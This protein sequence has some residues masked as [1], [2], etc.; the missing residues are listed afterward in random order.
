VLLTLAF[1]A[2]IISIVLIIVTIQEWQDHANQKYTYMNVFSFPEDPGKNPK[3]RFST[4]VYV[5]I[6]EIGIF[7]CGEIII[8]VGI[9]EI[10]IFLCGENCH[11]CRDF[12]NGDFQI[13]GE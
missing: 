9:F 1:I 2:G 5:G 10:G 11:L 7:L 6:F 8:Y 13:W 3:Y 4:W 12:Q